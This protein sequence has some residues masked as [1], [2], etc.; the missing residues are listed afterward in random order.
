MLIGG[1][2]Y[3]LAGAWWTVVFTGIA[4]VITVLAVTF[5]GDVLQDRIMSGG[6]GGNDGPVMRAKERRRR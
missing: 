3:I 4:I 2:N 1:Q 5:T 6:R